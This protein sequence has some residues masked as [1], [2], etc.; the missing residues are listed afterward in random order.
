MKAFLLRVT[1]YVESVRYVVGPSTETL[2]F[3]SKSPSTEEG[4]RG[5]L[6]ER[7]DVLAKLGILNGVAY[8]T[9]AV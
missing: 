3:S 9:I 5:S 2:G 1:P 7:L 6:D 4:I 8:V